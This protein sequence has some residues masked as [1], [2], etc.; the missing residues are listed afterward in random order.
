MEAPKLKLVPTGQDT[1]VLEEIASAKVA[2]RRN[3]DGRVVELRVLNR[4]G[5]WEATAR[6]DQ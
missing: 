4:Q 5:T 6:N 1:F 3:A 2:F